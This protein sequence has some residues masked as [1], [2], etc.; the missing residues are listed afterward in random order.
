MNVKGAR[1][2]C[3]KC[4]HYHMEVNISG[5]EAYCCARSSRGRL[6]AWQYG[7]DMDWCADTLRAYIKK[8][9][10]PW[11]CKR[12]E[13]KHVQQRETR[14]QKPQNVPGQHECRAFCP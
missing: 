6:L 5:A 7:L 11:W 2:E 8:H 4:P 13:K 3:D 14:K 1:F 12:R 10:S 9:F